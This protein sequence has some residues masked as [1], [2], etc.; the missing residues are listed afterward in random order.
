MLIAL[1]SQTGNVMRNIR[2]KKKQQKHEM[3]GKM[4]KGGNGNENVDFQ[5]CQGYL[6]AWSEL[7]I[8]RQ[9]PVAFEEGQRLH[10]ERE[11]NRESPSLPSQKCQRNFNG[12]R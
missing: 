3:A 7:L 6:P 9:S 11:R 2:I 10:R 8:S 5:G 4:K 12:S 1:G